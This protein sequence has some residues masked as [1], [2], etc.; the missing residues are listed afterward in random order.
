MLGAPATAYLV[1]RETLVH[2]NDALS[3]ALDAGIDQVLLLGAGYDTRAWRFAERLGKIPVFEVDHPSTAERKAKIVADSQL[4]VVDRRLVAVDFAVDRLED[5]L[6]D[7][8]FRA[9]A[10]TF[11]VWEGVSMYLTRAAVRDTLQV[12]R[13]QTGPGSALVMDWWFMVDAQDAVSTV[14]RMSPQMLHFL[15]EPITF[16]I[17][18]DDVA[19]FAR[20]EGWTCAEIATAA[21][22][23]ARYLHD[24]RHVYPAM[25][26]TRLEHPA[27]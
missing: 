25:Y 12:L 11:V 1:S 19:D 27:A 8:G 4:P 5:R 18:P 21:A 7:A 15:G 24:G 2:P 3:A 13:R 23:E 16:G 6:A 17:H 26:V 22:L 9:G 20:R 10:P 14:L